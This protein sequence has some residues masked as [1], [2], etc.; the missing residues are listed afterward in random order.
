MTNYG[1]D[2]IATET[3]V[4][5]RQFSVAQPNW[6]F[7]QIVSDELHDNTN[8]L[9]VFGGAVIHPVKSFKIINNFPS[10]WTNYPSRYKLTGF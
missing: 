4:D 9:A 7:S 3:V 8:P 10:S 1:D 5:S 6:F 2:T